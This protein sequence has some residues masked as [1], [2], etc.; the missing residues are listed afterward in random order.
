MLEINHM[1]QPRKE[2]ITIT[3]PKESLLSAVSH[4]SGNE[5]E[6]DPATSLSS[7]CEECEARDTASWLI[8]R[9]NHCSHDFLLYPGD[10]HSQGDKQEP[11]HPAH[12][13]VSE[14]KQG[15]SAENWHLGTT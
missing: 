10:T 13:H 4:C 14:I 1:G 8:W 15:F 2:E 3:E 9:Q 12:P 7:E 11:A 5:G 6:R